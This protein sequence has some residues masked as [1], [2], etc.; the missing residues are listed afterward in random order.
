MIE[1]KRLGELVTFLSGFAFKSS[2]FN[3]EG[4][5]LP[6]VRIRDVQ[7]GR[8]NT[9]Y[10][11]SYEPRFMI[12]DGD[13][14]IGMDGDFTISRWRGGP[15]LLNQRVC[16]IDKVSPLVSRRYL[17]HFLSIALKKIEDETP[18]VT[19]KHL[20]V[21]TLEKVELSLPTIEEQRRIAWALDQADALLAKRRQAISLLGD[22]AQSIFIEMFGD[23]VG[24]ERAWPLGTV[25]SL[26]RNFESGKSLAEGEDATESPYRILKIS[27]VTSGR[28]KAYESKPAPEGYEPPKSHFVRGGD[29]LFSRANTSE[30]IGATAFVPDGTENLLMPDKLWRFAWNYENNPSPWFVHYLFRQRSVRDVIRRNASGTSGSMKNISQHKVLAI[31]VG[32]PPSRFQGEFEQKILTVEAALKNAESQALALDEL[33]ATLQARAFRGEL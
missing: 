13:D 6:L 15:A 18:Y 32:I 22:L 29:L 3:G 5:G 19:V 12:D 17:S 8:S 10:S 11:G 24:N 7:A 33:F 28:F 25:S 16:K 23:L 9:Y 26:V 20:S 14:L 31:K 2:L 30:L 1:V 27:A 21:K 4:V